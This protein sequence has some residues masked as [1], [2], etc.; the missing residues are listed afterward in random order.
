MM[1]VLMWKRVRNVI[2]NY[3]GEALSNRDLILKD[4]G[5]ASYNLTIARVSILHY[6]RKAER[7]LAIVSASI[8]PCAILLCP[9]VRASSREEIS[10]LDPEL[11][12][13]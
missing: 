7:F 11:K 2:L 12:K 5:N 13:I 1:P 8:F 6:S 10:R 4:Q 9:L 3:A